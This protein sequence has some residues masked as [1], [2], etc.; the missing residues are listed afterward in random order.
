MLPLKPCES[1]NDVPP[2]KKD[3]ISIALTDCEAAN[4]LL[5]LGR[6]SNGGKASNQLDAEDKENRIQKAK[7]NVISKK[8]PQ[9]IYT[10]KMLPWMPRVPQLAP[11]DLISV[12]STSKESDIRRAEE[13][14]RFLRAKMVQ[15][16]PSSVENVQRMN[17]TAMAELDASRMM[18]RRQLMTAQQVLKDH[19]S[20]FGQFE[21][22]NK[23]DQKNREQGK[24]Y[25]RRKS[26]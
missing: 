19:N 12:P 22:L 10:L 14:Q 18:K 4:V 11:H 24:T 16:L 9:R 21:C 3:E 13:M 23:N 1:K 6:E 26:F 17:R 2:A 7:D 15:G 5:S 25:K 8:G 20:Q